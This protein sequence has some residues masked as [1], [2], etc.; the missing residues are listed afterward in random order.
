MKMTNHNRA[1]WMAKLLLPLI[2]SLS[3]GC[4]T[5]NQEANIDV[6]IDR[7]LSE[8]LKEC[9]LVRVTDVRYVRSD[10]NPNLKTNNVVRIIDGSVECA[11]SKSIATKFPV[12]TPVRDVELV[13]DVTSTQKILRKMGDS[14]SVPL[15]YSHTYAFFDE[16]SVPDGT[17]LTHIPGCIYPA[18]FY[19]MGCEFYNQELPITEQQILDAFRKKAIAPCHYTGFD[20][21]TRS[22]LQVPSGETNAVYYA[23]SVDGN[24]ILVHFASS[25][26]NKWNVGRA[27]FNQSIAMPY[28]ED[29]SKWILLKDTGDGCFRHWDWHK[30]IIDFIQ[31]IPQSSAIVSPN[32]SWLQVDDSGNFLWLINDYTIVETLYE[33]LKKGD[34]IC[35]VQ[36]YDT[37]RNEENRI[38]AEMRKSGKKRIRHHT[39]AS[40]E[41][42]YVHW[43][44]GKFMQIPE[45][46]GESA[47]FIDDEI[48]AP[49]AVAWNMTYDE[50]FDFDEDVA[51]RAYRE[52][53]EQLSAQARSGSK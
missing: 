30:E 31:M 53:A 19:W 12:G 33:T 39:S 36:L 45:S 51:I 38:I 40:K 18:L 9:A 16:I 29:R 27:N 43:D 44:N 1:A 49:F 5:N 3:G 17:K 23:G 34:R 10:Y 47:F 7:I 15:T 6:V 11:L 48:V 21:F 13:D 52:R 25:K 22:V 41:L 2:S 8:N 24:V 46:Q 35:T 26:V 14:D 50:L 4:I 20:N 37:N 42:C 28:T 32:S